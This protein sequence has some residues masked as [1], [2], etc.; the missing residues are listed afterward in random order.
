MHP[1]VRGT[2]CRCGSAA[3]GVVRGPQCNSYCHTAS[4]GC[5]LPPRTPRRL[6]ALVLRLLALQSQEDRIS[7]ASPSWS[8]VSTGVSRRRGWVCA[9][10]GRLSLLHRALS[11]RH[12]RGTTDEALLY[13]YYY[14]KSSEKTSNSY[15]ITN[16]IIIMR[17]KRRARL[18]P[19]SAVWLGPCA[20]S[21]SC[22]A[23]CYP[24]QRKAGG[25]ALMGGSLTVWRRPR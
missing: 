3:R 17:N 16:Y 1:A 13:R 20:Q 25:R 19:P 9:R 4:T 18:G 12:T 14:F 23:A 10:C 8:S 7:A 22:A 5:A 6:R 24:L 21:P 15:K 2:E 11:C